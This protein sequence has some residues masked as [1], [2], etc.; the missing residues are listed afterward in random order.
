[1]ENKTVEIIFSEELIQL[2]LKSLIG[3]KGVVVADGHE[4]YWVKLE[5]P[6]KDELEWFIPTRSLQI[7][8]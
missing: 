5:E 4:G 8:R 2:K 3:R 1:M 7:I 6:F